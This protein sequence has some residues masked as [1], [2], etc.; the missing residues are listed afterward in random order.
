M[1]SW[2]VSGT[3]DSVVVQ[4]FEMLFY[5]VHYLYEK[6][7]GTLASYQSNSGKQEHHSG[8]ITLGLGLSRIEATK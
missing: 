8:K 3:S 2:T 1:E 6:L 5:I 4:Y 7:P